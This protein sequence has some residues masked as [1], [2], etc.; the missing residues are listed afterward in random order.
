MNRRKF[1][2]SAGAAVAGSAVTQ[3]I[4]FGRELL[5]AVFASDKKPNIIF[6]LADDLGIGEVS[7]YGAENYKTPHID[8]LARGGLDV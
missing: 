1:I 2:R 4:V 3:N 8:E 5:P 6:I 7:C